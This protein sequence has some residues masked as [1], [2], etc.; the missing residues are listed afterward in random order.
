MHRRLRWAILFLIVTFSG[1]V[2]YVWFHFGESI[3]GE[4]VLMSYFLVGTFL[5]SGV[6]TCV[7]IALIVFSNYDKLPEEDKEKVRKIA[8]ECKAVHEGKKSWWELPRSQM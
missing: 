3:G 7:E 4:Q 1:A 5:F 8:D 2:G 6:W